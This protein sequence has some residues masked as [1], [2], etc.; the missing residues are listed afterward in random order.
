MTSPYADL[1]R[2]PLSAAALT[3]ALVRPGGLWSRVEVRD[4][5]GSTNAE[6]AGRAR[7][8]TDGGLVL[9]AESQPR[10]RG[11]RD[12]TWVTPPRAGI[13]ASLLLRPHALAP[14]RWPWLPLLT[15]VAVTEA[16]RRRAQVEAMLKWPNDVLVGERKLAGVLLE[17]VETATGPAAVVGFGINVTLRPEE[18][19]ADF[20][21]GAS[22]TSLLLEGAATTDRSVVLPEV[23]R[24]FEALYRPWVDGSQQAVDGLAASYAAR[25]ATV[26][27]HVRV[28]VPGGGAVEGLARRIDDRGRLVVDTASGERA[29]GAGDVVHVR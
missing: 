3:R 26:G 22:A 28:D 20:A 4:E 8:G 1:D 14:D 15:G 13:T 12:R 9:I 7:A 19:P 25:C 2:P 10:G 29:L 23:L 24:V 16:L 6:L 11:R 17:R 21:P 5:V 27:R 18:L